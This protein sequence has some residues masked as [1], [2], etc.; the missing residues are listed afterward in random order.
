MPGSANPVQQSV[1]VIQIRPFKGGWQCFEGP[2]VAPYWTGEKAKED[3][4][5]TRKRARNLD[6]EKFG[7]YITTIQSSALSPLSTPDKCEAIRERILLISY[8][9]TVHTRL[10]ESTTICFGGCPRHSCRAAARKHGSHLPRIRAIAAPSP[11]TLN[12]VNYVFQ[13]WSDGGAR[14]HEISTPAVNTT[15]STTFIK[16]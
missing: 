5:V 11:Q 13:S 14:S 8:A 1:P 2:G 15:F 10:C 9:A 6:A 3:A 7:F 4:I 16:P 12:G